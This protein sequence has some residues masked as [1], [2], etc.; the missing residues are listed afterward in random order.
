LRAVR[1][2]E[3]W[4]QLKEITKFQFLLNVYR[5][6]KNCT[7]FYLRVS[8]SVSYQVLGLGLSWTRSWR[9]QLPVLR[10]RKHLAL[11]LVVNV[12]AMRWAVLVGLS[13]SLFKILIFQRLGTLRW[14]GFL[15]FAP[16]SCRI[17]NTR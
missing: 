11:K 13:L 4:T 9:L 8:C 5:N 10:S 6:A 14:A 12:L 17:W 15:S 7:R 2:G 3:F 16:T 1:F